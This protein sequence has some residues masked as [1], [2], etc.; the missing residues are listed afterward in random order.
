MIS[1]WRSLAVAGKL[2]AEHTFQERRDMEF[3]VSSKAHFAWQPYTYLGE[4]HNAKIKGSSNAIF[5][6]SRDLEGINKKYR[7]VGL[8]KASWWHSWIWCARRL[9][10]TQNCAIEIHEHSHWAALGKEWICYKW[11]LKFSNVDEM[12]VSRA[13]FDRSKHLPINNHPANPHHSS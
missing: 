11:Q 9:K 13:E 7:E 5:I 1:C 2:L 10:R 3:A 4:I 12:K 6:H 8:L